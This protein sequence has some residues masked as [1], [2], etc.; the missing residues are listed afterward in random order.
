MTDETRTLLEESF[1]VKEVF[2]DLDMVMESMKTGNL[3]PI[4]DYMLNG[5]TDGDLQAKVEGATVEQ[6]EGAKAASDAAQKA[7]GL[8]ASVATAMVAFAAI[9]F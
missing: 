4:I 1:V 3:E 2:Q 6:S 9:Q 7:T 8:V 5:E